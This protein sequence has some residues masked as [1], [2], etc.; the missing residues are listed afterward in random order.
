MGLGLAMLMLSGAAM[1]AVSDNPMKV[2]ILFVGAHPDDESTAFATMARYVE[3]GYKAAVIT[4]TR[5]EGGGNAVGREQGH[6]LGILREAEEREAL[7]SIGIRQVYYLDRLD[8]GFTTSARAAETGW[9]HRK[10]VEQLVRY[11]RL[12]QPEIVMTMNP[13]PVGHGHHQYIARLASEAFFKCDRDD[14]APSQFTD[15]F[16]G[17]WQPKTLLYALEYGDGGMQPDLKIDTTA[18]SPAHGVSYAELKRRALR[19]Y[20]S[21]GW[22]LSDQGIPTGRGYEPFVRAFSFA[23]VDEGVQ[24]DLMRGVLTP[25]GQSPAHLELYFE[26]SNPYF[27]GRGTVQ[28]VK[29]SLWN[30]T[31]AAIGH[32]RCTLQVPSGWQVDGEKSAGDA[33]PVSGATFDFTVHVP[34]DA[35]VESPRSLVATFRWDGGTAT[36]RSLVLATPAVTAEIA[37]PPGLASFRSWAHG[38]GLDHLVRVVP[39]DVAVGA[40]EAATLPVLLT[41]HTGTAAGGTVH[42][43]CPELGLDPAGQAFRLAPAGTATATFPV[44]VADAAPGRYAATCRLET[45]PV[46]QGFVD[47]VPTLSIPRFATA[48]YPITRVWSGTVTGP[49]DLSADFA[50]HHDKDNLYVEINVRDDVVVSNIA[51]DD[52]KGHWRT[53]AVE[54]AIDPTGHSENTLTTFK[55]GVIPFNTLGQPMAARDADARPGLAQRTAPGLQLASHRNP[56]GYT[57]DVAVPQRLLWPSGKVPPRFGF[58]VMV[59]DNDGHGGK[60]RIAWSAWPDVQGTPRLWGHAT[61]T[62]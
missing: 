62:P 50:V 25:D 43:Q 52:N 20:R 44:K 61:L 11:Y 37:P 55:L 3:Q 51:P 12:M 23:P 7:R 40:G 19:A 34:A 28:H 46:A 29:V 30:G 27:V 5:G 31:A 47:V 38:L 54:I 58:N 4:A 9:G 21:Q 36:T 8:T 39:S 48:C 42:L 10:L 15:E 57:V 17:H 6:A 26:P 53:D 33:R 56:D 2:N 13:W 32:P 14:V 16:L 1:C 24:T 45:G 59:Y 60:A 41:N 22:D 35:S 18:V 49:A